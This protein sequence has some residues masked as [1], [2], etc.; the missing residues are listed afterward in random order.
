MSMPQMGSGIWFLITKM[1]GHAARESKFCFLVSVLTRYL[2]ATNCEAM[3]QSE[4]SKLLMMVPPSL[5]PFCSAC[6]IAISLAM[7]VERFAALR[8]EDST[9]ERKP[10]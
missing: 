7:R 1:A 6:S 4:L 9:S 8:F 10:V 5:F 2:L 3:R